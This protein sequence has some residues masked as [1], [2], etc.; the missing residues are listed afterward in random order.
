M[1]VT[2]QLQPLIERIDALAL[3][4]RSLLL[5]ATV[6]VLFLL[7]DSLGLDPALKAQQVTE[8]RIAELELKLGA[9]QQK[10][11]LL[12]SDSD[13]T[14]VQSGHA[15]RERLAAELE[16]LDAAILAQIGT[17]VEP[18]QASRVLEQVL[19]R[20]P[21]LRLQSMQAGSESL[22]DIALKENTTG[23]GLGRYQLELVVEGAY[24]DILRY[25]R[26]LEAMPWKFFWQN[27]DFQ[28][29]DYPQALTRLQLYTLGVQ[30]GP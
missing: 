23:S 30:D 29:S 4:E 15:A 16:E 1:A 19:A 24:L 2:M 5:F 9:L 22:D 8:Q 21:G 27:I 18:A 7:V 14:L 26:A 12:N 13:E 20:Y 17:L 11:R 28:V 10:A 3:R 25:L 6:V